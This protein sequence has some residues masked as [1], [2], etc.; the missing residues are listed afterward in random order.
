MSIFYDIVE[1]FPLPNP[2]LVL[3]VLVTPSCPINIVTDPRERETI[4]ITVSIDFI[5]NSHIILV[6]L[7]SFAQHTSLTA[8]RSIGLFLSPA[9]YGLNNSPSR[10]IGLNIS[11][12]RPVA[13]SSIEAEFL[14]A[15]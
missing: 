9:V 13:T 12:S 7:L 8:E 15:I 10:P 4:W 1:T 3:F 5:P 6:H 2:T 14:A 11:P